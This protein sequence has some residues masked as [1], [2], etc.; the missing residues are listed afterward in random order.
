MLLI[1]TLGE[2][3]DEKR[4]QKKS[5]GSIVSYQDFIDQE[6]FL[7]R[8]KIMISEEFPKKKEIMISEEFPKENKKKKKKE[9]KKKKRKFEVEKKR[10]KRKVEVEK[11][12]KK[13]KMEL[14]KKDRTKGKQYKEIF[15]FGNIPITIND[16][17]KC[18]YGEKINDTIIEFAIEFVSPPNLMKK[19]IQKNY[20]FCFKKF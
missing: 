13:R 3:R 7:S 17:N 5:C 12:I 1:T 10:K 4:F 6:T 19:I 16:I 11:K 9:N 15:R 18:K 2:W 14:E 8:Y 20:T